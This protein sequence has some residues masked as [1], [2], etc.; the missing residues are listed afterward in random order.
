MRDKMMPLGG[1]D[2]LFTRQMEERERIMAFA[3][4]TQQQKLK[5]WSDNPLNNQDA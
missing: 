1:S 2:S 5:R 3:L 4:N